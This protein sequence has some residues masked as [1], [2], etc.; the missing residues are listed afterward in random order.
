MRQRVLFAPRN[1]S[2]Q[3]AEY[4]E[5]IRPLGFDGEVWSYGP[6]AFGFAADRVVDPDRLL[7][8]PRFR[9]ELFDEAIRRFDIFHFQYSRSLLP[10]EG[11]TLPEL[12][13][14]PLLRSLGKRVI[15]NFRGSDVRLP[16]EHVRRE[17]DS[18][19]RAQVGTVD[20][21]RIRGRVAIC[22]RFCDALLVSTPGLLD[23][24]PDARWLPHVIDVAT[25][26]TQ[27][28]NEP[29]IPVVLHAP[30]SRTAKSSDIVDAEMHSLA[31]DGTIDYRPVEGL[32]RS[33]LQRAIQTADIVIDS[34][35]IG[36]HGLLSVEAMAAGAIPIAHVAATNRGRN[37]GLPVVESTIHD[38]REVVG[39]LAR[40][41]LRRSQLRMECQGFVMERHDRQAV[42][43]ELVDLYRAPR[44]PVNRAYPDWPRSDQQRRIMALETR[45]DEL[46]ADVDPLVRGFMPF[47]TTLPRRV[48]DQLI[49]TIEELEAE[50][51]ARGSDAPTDR[52][53]R[54]TQ[55]PPAGLRDRLKAHP[56]IHRF[57]RTARRQLARVK[58]R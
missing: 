23:D 35:T 19:L 32:S 40:D 28:G 33:D 45:I 21:D 41:P 4:A 43:P 7:A 12:W 18:Y 27:R 8:D 16:S 46:E 57:V 50:L 34:L 37:P 25:W 9:W 55:A 47:R 31:R 15:M 44:S 24:V 51:A 22:R 52:G 14:L 3:A 49:A 2:G 1:I 6:P 53:R 48:A 10:P 42:G 56:R 13:D 38:L 58:A 54:R 39:S 20:E 5:A 30:S 11:I 26:R 17:P 36:D 29:D